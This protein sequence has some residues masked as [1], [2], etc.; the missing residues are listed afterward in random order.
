MRV[1]LSWLRDY[2]DVEMD[3]DDLAA[4][5]T[6][7]GTEVA[8]VEGEHGRV[9]GVLVVRVRE[10]RPHPAADRLS[11]CEVDWGR[12]RS[13]VVCGAPNVRKGML[14]ALAL[15]GA[16]LPGGRLIKETEIRGERSSGMLC[17][18]A[19]LGV[20]DDQ[21]GILEL[22]EGFELGED[23]ARLLGLGEPVLDLEITPNRPDCLSIIGVAREVAVLTGATLRLPDI[24]LDE[25]GEPIAMDYSVEIIDEDLCSRYVARLIEDVQ[26]G[27]S[28]LW[29]QYR[30]KQAGVR[31]ISNAVDVTNYVMLETGQPLHAF[32]ADRIR[33]GKVLVRRAREGEEIVTLDGAKRRLHPHSLLICDP[34]GPIALAGVMGG[35]DSEVTGST[36]R[37]LLESAHFNPSSILRTS[38]EQDLPSEAAYRFERGVD[39]GGCLRAAD[40]ASALLRE[41]TKGRVRKGFIDVGTGEPERVRLAL[42]LPRA[43]NILGVGLEASWVRD[44]LEKLGCEVVKLSEERMELVAPTFRPDL[45]REIDL[46]EEL[47]RIHGYQNIPST[48]PSNRTRGG[49][50][51]VRQRELRKIR[52]LLVG[53]GLYETISYSFISPDENAAFTQKESRP[54]VIANPLSEEQS[55]MRCTV[56]PGLMSTLL[57]NH[58]RHQEDA[59]IFEIGRVFNS[60][61][62]SSLPQ[63]GLRLGIALM[64]RWIPRQWDR[65]EERAD[66]YTLKGIWETLLEALRFDD[67]E[68]RPL[69]REY[70][71]PRIAA[72]LTV[73]GKAVGEMGL[74]H[75]SLLK[76]RDLPPG[77]VLLQADLDA[78]LSTERVEMQY[79]EIP[80]Y[81]SVQMDLSVMAPR[82]L[83]AS[84]IMEV[85]KECGGELLKEVR[86]FDLYLGK[87]VAEREKSLTF[88]LVF[89]DLSRTLREEE[90]KS[91]FSNIV[92]C[93]RD[94]L[95]V[96][97]RT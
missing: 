77:V 32:D 16:V 70:F 28:P 61:E 69:R 25:E 65:E 21:S 29:M 51:T 8:A 2:V 14:A 13:T 24:R 26:T 50:L 41:L 20:N 75:P 79:R 56:Y 48:L 12:D 11:L 47:A 19:E 42:R 78:L 23:L 34:G 64:G 7:A 45:E 95:G 43:R 84:K 72:E 15:P 37:I 58:R 35:L 96:R 10:V 9:V 46:V 1:P 73:R 17:S 67:H 89:Y 6:D 94:R 76:E 85:V 91:A 53:M 38:R 27:P 93:L 55:E 33:Q 40:R 57:H 66:F 68:L 3:A 92:D 87:G 18:G 5:L 90:A 31:S 71:H 4:L 74:L 22:E 59:G 52:E 63:E 80:R 36:R 30:L 60:T 49:G 97:L 86:L 44:K 82:E 88:N 62:D 39:P 54:V 83:E 81:P